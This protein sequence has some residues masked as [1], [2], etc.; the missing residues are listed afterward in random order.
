MPMRGTLPL[1]NA[2]PPAFYTDL[3]AIFS[4]VTTGLTMSLWF[5]LVF[6]TSPDL[7][8]VIAQLG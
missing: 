2:K 1:P 6:P 4:L 5:A 8:I 7:I 3:L